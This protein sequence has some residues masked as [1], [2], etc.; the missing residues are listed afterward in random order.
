MDRCVAAAVMAAV[1][2]GCGG[3]V[4]TG[5]PGPG[6]T[7]GVTDDADAARGGTSDP[8]TGG[9][10]ELPVCHLGRAKSESAQCVFVVAERC[11]ETKLDA[12]ACACKKQAGTTCIDGFPDPDGT[13]KVTCE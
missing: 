12:C 3:I 7:S 10:V 1:L 5:D 6:G 11:Y 4:R 9:T 13:T 2:G 8:G